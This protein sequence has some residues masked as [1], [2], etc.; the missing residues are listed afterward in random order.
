MPIREVPPAEARRLMSDEGYV[1]L[2]VRTMDEFTAGHPEGAWNAPVMEPGRMGMQPNPD[3][4]R[5]VAAK[6]PR[7][8]KLVVGCMAGGR[9]MRACQILEGEGYET[10]VNVRGGFGGARDG[11]GRVIEKGWQEAGLPVSTGALPERL[12]KP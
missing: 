2:D 10:L 5:A 12:L 4:V 1:Y 9:S 11:M 6:F 3:F 7:N 8:T